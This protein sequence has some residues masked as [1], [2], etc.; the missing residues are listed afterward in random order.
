MLSSVRRWVGTAVLSVP[1]VK[2]FR[3]FTKIV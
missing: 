1:F 3:I 2:R